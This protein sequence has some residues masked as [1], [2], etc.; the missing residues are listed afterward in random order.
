M[1]VLTSLRSLS[2]AKASSSF[3]SG[4]LYLQYGDETKQIQVSSGVS[5]LD[6]VRALFVKAFPQQLTLKLLQSPNTVICI[7]DSSRNSYYGLEDVR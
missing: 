1:A 7:K 5:S 4:V 6:A 3:L 2:K